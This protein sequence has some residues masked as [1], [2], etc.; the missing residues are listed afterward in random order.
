MKNLEIRTKNKMPVEGRAFVGAPEKQENTEG[1]EVFFHKG[2]IGFGDNQRY[3]FAS[4]P[5]VEYWPLKVLIHQQN[6]LLYFLIVEDQIL[7]S[8]YVSH[9]IGALYTTFGYKKGPTR[10]YF[11]VTVQGE[12]GSLLF[13]INKR[14][15]LLID[16]EGRRGGQHI[17]PD[18]D[19]PLSCELPEFSK[20]L[21]ARVKGFVEGQD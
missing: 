15:P 19:L 8:P 3:I 18:K 21:C 2:I 1:Q 17:L 14:A 20:A 11:I 9:D 12:S 13:S 16:H 7:G 10:C 6:P 5:K 4:F